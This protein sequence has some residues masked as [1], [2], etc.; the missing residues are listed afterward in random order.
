MHFIFAAD[1]AQNIFGLRGTE[2][3]LRALFGIR[4]WRKTSDLASRRAPGL[5]P[6][7]AKRHY[8]LYRELGFQLRNMTPRHRVKAELR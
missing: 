6:P 5:W 8:Y 2:S 7:K 1:R 3:A 4:Y